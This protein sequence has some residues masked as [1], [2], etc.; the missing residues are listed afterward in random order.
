MRWFWLIL[1]LLACSHFGCA[2]SSSSG[3]APAPAPDAT[4]DESPDRNR[5]IAPLNLRMLEEADYPSQ[6]GL[7]GLVQLHS[8]KTDPGG[9]GDTSKSWLMPNAAFGDLDGD[10]VKDAVAVLVTDTG[11]GG[12]FYELFAILNSDGSPVPLTG[13]VLGDRIRVNAV[14]ILS[15]KI[16]V[17]LTRQAPTDPMNAPTLRAKES[18]QVKDGQLVRVSQAELTR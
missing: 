1:S 18:Y 6:A 4:G 2:G 5:Y 3:G 14:G 8:G 15:D 17:D 9:S 12:V 13:L 16:F 11:S 7:G 10:G